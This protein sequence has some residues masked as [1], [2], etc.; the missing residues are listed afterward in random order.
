MGQLTSTFLR[1]LGVVLPLV[2]TAWILVWFVTGTES[3]LRPM[4]L[5]VIPEQYY[6]PGLGLVFGVIV[7]YATGVLVQWFVIKRIWEA[8]ERLLERIP[9]IK[10]V[11]TALNDFFDFFSRN[12][13]D[14]AA[15]V[16]SVDVGG[17]ALLIG[18]V[19]DDSPR[20]MNLSG[21]SED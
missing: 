9:L 5:F 1:G 13:S 17:G 15:T 8:L 6:V 11:Y 10:T 7:V 3:L 21:S 12:R 14:D 2:L 4:F 19:T 16:V 20:A 18:F